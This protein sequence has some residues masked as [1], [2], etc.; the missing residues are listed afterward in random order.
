MHE[1]ETLDR[2]ISQHAVTEDMMARSHKCFPC[3]MGS[4]LEKR[5]CARRHLL[6]EGFSDALLG[7]LSPSFKTEH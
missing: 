3:F 4:S 5:A 7:S 2:P 6:S 1:K